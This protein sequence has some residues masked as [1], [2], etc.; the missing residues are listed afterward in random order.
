M[1]NLSI[2]TDCE[3]V[4]RLGWKEADKDHPF[5]SVMDDINKMMKEH[6]CVILHTIRDGNQCADHMARFGG[7]LKNNTV[8]EEPPMTL[9]SYLLRDIE[10]AYEFERNNHDY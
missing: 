7:T 1:S 3:A 8:F 6:K 2:E 5:K 4:M 10:A 9:K